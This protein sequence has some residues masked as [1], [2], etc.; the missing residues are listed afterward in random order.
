MFFW[1]VV[2]VLFM[3]CGVQLNKIRSC[4]D[5]T[6]DI[7]ENVIIANDNDMLLYSEFHRRWASQGQLKVSTVHVS[8]GTLFLIIIKATMHHY[9]RVSTVHEK[10]TQCGVSGVLGLQAKALKQQNLK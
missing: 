2:N 6:F 1:L 8:S 7:E 4:I 3:H 5:Q 10:C 9:S